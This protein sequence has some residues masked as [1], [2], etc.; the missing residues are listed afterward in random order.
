MGPAYEHIREAMLG[1]ISAA[2]LAQ[3]AKFGTARVAPF[4]ELLEKL[5][6]VKEEF[7]DTNPEYIMSTLQLRLKG[8]RGELGVRPGCFQR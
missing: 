2:E 3:I 6:A 7:G 8:L 4:K 5:P 1:H